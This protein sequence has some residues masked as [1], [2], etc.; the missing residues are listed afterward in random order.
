MPVLIDSQHLHRG[1]SVF[2]ANSLGTQYSILEGGSAENITWAGYAYN[3]GLATLGNIIGGAFFVAGVYWVGSPRVRAE[4]RAAANLNGAPA[5][6]D[7]LAKLA[8]A[9]VASGTR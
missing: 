1:L 3:V 9:P 4:V 6:G 5:E 2:S 7:A 8:E